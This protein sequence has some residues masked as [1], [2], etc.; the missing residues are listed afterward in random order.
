MKYF[1]ILLKFLYLSPHLG[2]AAIKVLWY[3][4]Q[5][6]NAS[7]FV[8]YP[9]FLSVQCGAVQCSAVQCGVQCSVD[10]GVEHS[11]CETFI[12]DLIIQILTV[13]Q[14]LQIFKTSGWETLRLRQWIM[15]EQIYISGIFYHI[16][17]ITWYWSSWFQFGRMELGARQDK[18]CHHFVHPGF[19]SGQAPLP[20]GSLAVQQ[21]SRVLPVD[22]TGGC[23]RRIALRNQLQ[24]RG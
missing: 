11:N 20:Q 1:P 18:S 4:V 12:P 15:M 5:A 17:W 16:S 13:S 7:V 6:G 21:N 8:S 9:D 3:I 22:I 2:A 14:L 19:R 24:L 23:I 10:E